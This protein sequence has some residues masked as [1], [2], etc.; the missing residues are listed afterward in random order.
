MKRQRIVCPVA[1]LVAH[2][3]RLF[4]ERHN[5]CAKEFLELNKKTDILGFLELGYES[6]HLTGEDGVLD[7]IDR[8]VFEF[9]A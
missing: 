3:A 5:L 8:Y 7:E 4:M 1:F 2:Y 6:F 9:G